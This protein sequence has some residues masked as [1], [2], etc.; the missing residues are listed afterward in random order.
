[1]P[2]NQQ[3]RHLAYSVSSAMLV[4]LKLVT[5]FTGLR[6][7]TLLPL[8]EVKLAEI[9]CGNIFPKRYFRSRI[10]LPNY[11]CIITG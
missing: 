1:M 8:D 3:L 10:A 11:I 6:V 5:A 2:A 4:S 9:G 7:R